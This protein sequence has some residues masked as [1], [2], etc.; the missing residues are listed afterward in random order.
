VAI[1]ILTDV[2]LPIT[3]DEA[4]TWETAIAGCGGWWQMAAEGVV[5]T[6]A[7]DMARA[8]P[9]IWPNLKAAQRDPPPPDFRDSSLYNS[10]YKGFCPSN[11]PP[12]SV[13]SYRPAGRG[14]QTRRAAFDPSIVGN[15]RAWLEERL[16][17]LVHFEAAQ[18]EGGG[19]PA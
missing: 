13:I 1:D 11:S 7:T 15:P 9:A 8:F 16:G 12:W 6:S 5:L 17:P 19:S 4:M 18:P 2:C 10:F 3:V 14:Q